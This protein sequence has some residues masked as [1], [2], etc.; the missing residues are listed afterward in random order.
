MLVNW[1][2]LWTPDDGSGFG[3]LCDYEAPGID[4]SI[5]YGGTAHQMFR[6]RFYVKFRHGNR[7]MNARF[8]KFSEAMRYVADRLADAE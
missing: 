8:D 5:W 3:V 7:H 6:Y 2:H 4:A 1:T